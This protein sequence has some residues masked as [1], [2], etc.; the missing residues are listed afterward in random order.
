MPSIHFGWNLLVGIALV[1]TARPVAV[2]VFGALVPAAMAL[3]VIVTANHYILDIV[4]G[5]GVCLVSLA[6]ARALAR[7]SVTVVTS[8]PARARVRRD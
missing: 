7:R 2:R 8:A 4:A 1:T 6:V 5:A 3:S